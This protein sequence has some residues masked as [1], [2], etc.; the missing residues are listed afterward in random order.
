MHR[1]LAD[2][3][4]ESL[5]ADLAQSAYGVRTTKPLVG[6]DRWLPRPEAVLPEFTLAAQSGLAEHSV[7]REGRL[8]SADGPVTVST[9]KVEAAVTVATAKALLLKVGSVVHVG[10]ADGP[11]L[12]VRITG[13]IEP[14]HS[15]RGYWSGEQI[16]RAPGLDSKPSTPPQ[17]YWQAGLLLAP[18][19]APALLGTQGEPHV[20]WRIALAVGHL[21]AQDVPALA[22]QVASLEG[23]PGLLDLRRVA[24]EH[25]SLSTDLDTLLTSYT[26]VRSAIT[27][28]VAVAAFGI[29]TVASVAVVMTGGLLAVRRSAELALLRARGGSLRGIGGRLLAET[30]V[31]ALPAA[32][33]GLFLSVLVVSEGR[34]LPAVAGASA[35]A[36]TA[37]VALPVRALVLH[38][39][40]RAHAERDDVA[41]SRPSKRRT[42][43]EVTLLVL[44]AGAV[45]ALQRGEV[46]ETGGP[47]ASSAPTLIGMTAS[48][49]VARLYPLLLRR[50]MRLMGRLRGTVVF[51]ALARAGRSS[52][53][54]AALPLLALFAA[55]TTTAFG[56]SVLAGIADTRD[57]A[58]LSTTGADAR[59]SGP[60]DMAV[61]PDGV[62]R[63]V[64]DAKGV[65][66]VMAVQVEHALEL[67]PG[68]T[69]SRNAMSATLVGVEPQTYS[70]LARQRELGAFA[71]GAL[72]ITRNT[73]KPVLHAVASPRVAARLGGGPHRLK[74]L[75]GT[76]TVK[77]HAVRTHTP[78]TTSTDF[79]IVDA[80]GLSRR[81]ATV[82]LAE[83]E[84]LDGEA[85]RGT[86]RGISGGLVVRLRSEERA[87][88]SD[89]P[90][91]S[92]AERMYAVALV[93][94]A[95]YAGLA[96]L[97]SLLRSAP[98]RAMLLAGMRTLG[99]PV[100]HGR[101]LP[102]LEVL[103]Q[104]LLA[105]VGGAL[106]GWAS[107]KLLSPGVDLTRLA[108]ATAP[109]VALV[110]GARLRADPWS[111]VLPAVGVVV[112]AVVVAIAQTLHMRRCR[113]ATGSKTGDTR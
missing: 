54:G 30:S 74:A 93:V 41:R 59:I 31:I 72:R 96:L 43:A 62:K 113:S 88:F 16:L 13:I 49:V 65:G 40:A 55:L 2:R 61:L 101:H 110:G 84:R 97:I 100:R 35:V 45:A 19:A 95:G 48:I 108:L 34:L 83:G 22:E 26:T 112:L 91:Q 66:A 60:G 105:A 51:L 12:D 63:A 24:G 90:M 79:L 87:A 33:L 73:G 80:A 17:T 78:A 64:R 98:D 3:L 46:I 21:T 25:V 107:I 89:S 1:R 81:A 37:S 77:V 8:P 67:P 5:Q 39:M 20:Y 82:L 9:T 92:G 10:T 52:A 71:P 94:G 109:D 15:D 76:F 106:A 44:T 75:A 18:E 111:L 104:A 7:V 102:T 6:Q 86:V 36:F 85:L 29:G 103:P 32:G 50:S 53:T 14:R 58:A 57:R 4:P 56:G 28:I 42:A 23:G 99:L 68:A 69:G 38:R 70:R 27:P 47:L 11:Q